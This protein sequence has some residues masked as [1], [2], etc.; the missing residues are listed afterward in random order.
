MLN[1]NPP[2]PVKCK[3]CGYERGMHRAKSLQ[4]PAKW[5]KG[6]VGFTAYLETVYEPKPACGVALPA[7]VPLDP[8]IAK[9][10]GAKAWELYSRADDPTPVSGVTACEAPSKKGG[11]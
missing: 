10:V 2:K 8:D 4:C 1:F 6:R 3:H 5:S 11:A 7:Q 9:A